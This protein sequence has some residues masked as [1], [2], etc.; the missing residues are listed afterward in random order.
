MNDDQTDGCGIRTKI[1]CCQRQK[2]YVQKKIHQV[3]FMEQNRK[4]KNEK[5]KKEI[6][7]QHVPFAK[8]RKKKFNVKFVYILKS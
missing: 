3:G 8:E 1:N 4:E 5:K 7:A 6:T 2:L